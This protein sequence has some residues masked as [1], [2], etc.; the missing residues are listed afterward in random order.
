[1]SGLSL[2]LIHNICSDSDSSI[3]WVAYTVF[4]ES[5]KGCLCAFISLLP[6]AKYKEVLKEPSPR[7]EREKSSTVISM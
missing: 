2:A 1:M 5:K 7:S 6:K 4:K 3:A